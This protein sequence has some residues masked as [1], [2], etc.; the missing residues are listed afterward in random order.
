MTASSDSSL[1]QKESRI[2]LAEHMLR[3]MSSI[4]ATKGAIYCSAPITSGR[5]HLQWLSK[6]GL[7]YDNVDDLPSEHALSHR[8]AV[9]RKNREHARAVVADLRER[10]TVPVIDPTA[11]GHIPGWSQANWLDFW[12]SVIA[13]FAIRVVFLD[14]WQFSAGCSAEFLFAHTRSIPAFDERGNALSLIDGARL[15]ERAIAVNTSQRHSV[16]R[17]E[18]VLERIRLLTDATRTG[19]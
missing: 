18:N 13:K 11:M 5:R 12:Q 3:A 10:S 2:D 8:D 4:I 9:V 1:N 17:I 19:E 14:D 7:S 6:N 16:S 15:I